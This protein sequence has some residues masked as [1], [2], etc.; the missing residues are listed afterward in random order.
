MVT[1]TKQE[2]DDTKRASLAESRHTE[3]SDA[4]LGSTRNH[5][6][7]VT[8]KDHSECV[9]NSVR[10]CCTSCGHR[11]IRALWSK[12]KQITS[13]V[14]HLTV[15]GFCDTECIT[16]LVLDVLRP[17]YTVRFCRMQPR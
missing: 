8:M 3:W 16:V 13:Y 9:S 12:R 15:N 6:I 14:L 7:R 5:N 10:T 1:Y 2:K 17:I 4:R 11:V